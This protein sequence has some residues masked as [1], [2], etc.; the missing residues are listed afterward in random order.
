[1]SETAVRHAQ[2]DIVVAAVR[3]LYRTSQPAMG[4]RVERRALGWFQHP[5]GGESF[6]SVTVDAI[7]PAAVPE[8]L[9]EIRRVYGHS[10][11]TVNVDDRARDA[12]LG[13]ALAAAG[14]TPDERT[15]FLAFVGEPP[16]VARPDGVEVAESGIDDLDVW[17]RIKLQGFGN[18]DA[19]PDGDALAREVSL[20][21]AEIRG[22][23]RLRLA[24]VDDEPACAIAFYDGPDLLI[25]NLATP[26]RFRGRGLARLL[27]LD[28]VAGADAARCRSAVINADEEDWPVTWYHRLGFTDEVYWRHRYR[29]PATGA[30]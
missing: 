4:Y 3:E 11:V 30:S 12:E 10:A 13:P 7:E 22:E 29:L 8:L 1:M 6:G 25:F 18:S 14:F 19:E 26:P 20:R 24:L 21:R 2:H 27:L 17:A 28:T 9:A 5:P 15:T 16:V 23:A